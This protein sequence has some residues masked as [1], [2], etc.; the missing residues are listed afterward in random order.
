MKKLPIGIQDFRVLREGDYLYVDKTELIHE[1]VNAGKYYFLSRPRRFGKSLL[2]STLRELFSGQKELFHDL[3]IEKHWDWTQ[4][5]PVIHFSF[6]QLDYR[7]L[8]LEEAIL[9]QLREMAER[10]GLVL[11]K[12]TVKQRL[13]EYISRLSERGKVVLLVDEYDRP[14]IDYIDDLDQAAE[15]REILRSFY[16]CIKDLDPSLR[17]VLLTG[18]SKFSKVSIFSDLNN[19]RDITLSKQYNNLAGYTQAELTDYFGDRIRKLALEMG[20]EKEQ[21]VR[22]IKSWYNGY[23]WMGKDRLYNP[24][25]VLNFFESGQFQNFWF[26]TGTPTFLVKLMR[27]GYYFQLNDL[28]VGSTQMDFFDIEDPDLRSILFQTGYLTLKEQPFPELYILG[29]PNREVEISLL[30]YM[31]A[32]YSYK[33]EGDA[34]PMALK[35]RNALQDG[36]VERFVSMID[37]LFASIPERIFRR[38]NESAYHAVVYTALSLMGFYIDSE[39]SVGDGIVDAVVKT[40]D[41]IYVIEFKYDRSPTEAIEQIR[42]KNYAEP[43]RYDGRAVVLLGVSF[44]KEIKGVTGWKEEAL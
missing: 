1:M 39:V 22:E 28:E 29:Y 37:S 15:N 35:I 33:K 18:V 26:S 7:N 10:Q 9:V 8:G 3:W 19:L 31:V 17:F 44:G 20:M 40:P 34:V 21:L 41:R 25:S 36:D 4:T 11:E 38:R 42:E 13:T 43:Y 5:S 14:I 32:A 24:F 27:K 30:Q 16:S 12:P 2:L 6:S 23:S